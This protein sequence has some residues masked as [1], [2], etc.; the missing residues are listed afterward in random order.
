[1]QEGIPRLLQ[2]C[3]PDSDQA[4]WVAQDAA[5]QALPEAMQAAFLKTQE[6]FFAAQKVRAAF[7]FCALPSCLSAAA[8][9][10]PQHCTNPSPDG[11]LMVRTAM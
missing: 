3:S 11:L 5:A 1:M 7:A 8:P 10:E 2:K 9:A 4:A 6:D